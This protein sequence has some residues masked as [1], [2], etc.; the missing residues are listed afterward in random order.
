MTKNILL[1]FY[2]VWLKTFCAWSSSLSQ[3]QQKSKTSLRGLI[4][5]CLDRCSTKC[6][7]GLMFPFPTSVGNLL[8]KFS[9]NSDMKHSKNSISWLPDLF[10][11]HDLSSKEQCIRQWKL[12][13]LVSIRMYIRLYKKN[14]FGHPWDYKQH[15]INFTR[16]FGYDTEM[17][18]RSSENV[19]RTFA[20]WSADHTIKTQLKKW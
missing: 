15:S 9:R 13:K 3:L 19:N 4:S 14:I 5:N 6:H 16:M 2:K 20:P 1:L 7:T 12:L 10:W 17:C 8:E 18:Q 11:A